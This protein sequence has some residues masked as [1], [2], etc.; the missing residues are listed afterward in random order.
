MGQNG[1][2][3]PNVPIFGLFSLALE[4]N[5]PCVRVRQMLLKF[6]RQTAKR[7]IHFMHKLI[8]LLYEVT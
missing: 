5:L 6:C 2:S 3:L 1:H 7:L 8:Q 4:R